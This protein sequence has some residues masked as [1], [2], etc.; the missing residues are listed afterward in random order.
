[1]QESGT[2]M[3]SVRLICEVPNILKALTP[4]GEGT[5]ILEPVRDAIFSY[6]DIAT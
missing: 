4:M 5:I 3:T 1:M 6:G 2:Q